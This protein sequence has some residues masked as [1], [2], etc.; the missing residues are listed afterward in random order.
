MTWIPPEVK[1]DNSS[2]QPSWTP[3][4]VKEEE[5]VSVGDSQSLATP[6]VSTQEEVATPSATLS[7][8]EQQT[9]APDFMGLFNKKEQIKQG[10]NVQQLK[11]VGEAAKQ[12]EYPV[13][14]LLNKS[15]VEKRLNGL[16]TSFPEVA[17]QVD[18]IKSQ[19]ITPQNIATIDDSVSQIEDSLVP[20]AITLSAAL[21]NPQVASSIVGRDKQY[22]DYYKNIKDTESKATT[23]RIVADTKKLN[24]AYDSR[25]DS[26]YKAVGSGFSGGIKEYFDEYANSR[27][28]FIKN[29]KVVSLIEKVKNMKN[30][31]SI[32]LSSEDRM[33]LKLWADNDA[34][35]KLLDDSIP[36]SY[37]IGKGAGYSVPYMGEFLLTAWTGTPVATAITR[38]VTSKLAEGAAVSFAKKQAIGLSAKLAATGIQTEFMPS[39]YRKTAEDV[40][41]GEDFGK[42]LL[43][44]YYSTFAENFTERLFLKNPWDKEAVGLVDGF[45]SKL[46][47]NL[48]SDKGAVGALYSLGE[49]YVEEKTS[50]LMTAP[51]DSNSFKEFW[52]NFWDVEKNGET[53]GSVALITL[54]MS[55]ASIMADKIGTNRVGKKIPANIKSEIDA[56]LADKKL[57]LK[58]QYD[59]VG[60]IVSDH[61]EDTDL[62]ST[63]GEMAG[64][65]IN[66]VTRKTRENVVSGIEERAQAPTVGTREEITTEDQAKL[67]YLESKGV[68]VPDGS[69]MATVNRL[70][71]EEKQKET[72][73]IKEE[74]KVAESTGVKPK[75]LRDVYR[76]GREIF[77]LN[78]AQALAQAIIVDRVVA[79]AAKNSGKTKQQIYSEIEYRKAD[80]LLKQKAGVYFQAAWHGSPYQID[81]FSWDHIGK[82]EGVQA[83]GWGGYFSDLRDIGED[84]ARKLAKKVLVIGDTS[85][86]VGDFISSDEKISNFEEWMDKTFP[87]KN[88]NIDSESLFHVISSL[89]WDRNVK[90]ITS[91][92]IKSIINERY[93]KKLINTLDRNYLL[94]QIKSISNI[95]LEKNR[96]LYKVEL[97]KGKTTEQ[98]DWLVWDKPMP[99]SM[100]EKI[101]KYVGDDIFNEWNEIL[102]ENTNVDLTDGELTGKEIYSFLTRIA[103]EDGLPNSSQI[104]D[105]IQ[106]EASLFLLRAGI[107][108]I[109]YPAESIARG[110]T[111]ETARG[112]NYVVFD[113]N[114]VTIEEVI[115]FQK[116]L[117]GKRGAMAIHDGKSLIYALTDPNVSTPLHEIAH[118]YERYMLPSEKA[119]VLAWT[120]HK[121]WS[122]ETSEKF[123]RGFEKYLA[124]GVAPTE[125]LKAVFERFKTWLIDIYNGIKQ[126]EI[127]VELN[128][129]MKRLYDSILTGKKYTPS[130]EKVATKEQEVP[131]K[132]YKDV[133]DLLFQV[134]DLLFQ[135]EDVKFQDTDKTERHTKALGNLISHLESEKSKDVAKEVN[136]YLKAKGNPI[137]QELIDKVLK[138]KGYAEGIRKQDKG[139]LGTQK[140][141]D[142]GK[143]REIPVG[144]NGKDKKTP[145]GK[146]EKVTGETKQR[147]T[148]TSTLTKAG[149]IWERLA[150]EA[151]LFYEVRKESEAIANAVKWL[152]EREESTIQNA[153]EGRK[154]GTPWERMDRRM[155][156][157]MYLKEKMSS[158]IEQGK[159]E[160]ANAVWENIKKIEEAVAKEGTEAGWT[161]Q[162]L[163]KFKRLDDISTT[164]VINNEIAKHNQSLYPETDIKKVS[165]SEEDINK[166][167]KEIVN[168]AVDDEKLTNVV[169][170]IAEKNKGKKRTE[171]YSEKAKEIADKLR[172]V[173]PSNW[174]ITLA[175]GPIS[176]IGIG[177]LDGAVET[178]AKAIE[179]SGNI[180]DSINKGINQIKRSDWYK[181]LNGKQKRHIE[182]AFELN[183]KKDLG[184]DALDRATLEKYLKR[185]MKDLGV[186]LKYIIKE[187]WANPT[188][189]GTKLSDRIVAN[190]GL[191]EAE[192]KLVEKTV[193]D[194]IRQKLEDKIT[195]SILNES[196][197]KSKAQKEIFLN[198]MGEFLMMGN[199]EHKYFREAFAE[200]FGL[201]PDITAEQVDYLTKLNKAVDATKDMGVY[202]DIVANQL[203]Q[204]IDKLIPKTKTQEL[205]GGMIGLD[206]ANALSGFTTHYINLKS[207]FWNLLTR[208]IMDVTDGA[209][210]IKS[211]KN[212]KPSQMPIANMFNSWIDFFF[213]SGKGMSEFIDIVKN[214]DLR[215]MHK[216]IS[217][218]KSIAHLT[219]PELER[220][221]QGKDRFKAVTVNINGKQ[222]DINVANY[223]KFVGRALAAE[224][225]FSTRGFDAVELAN[226]LRKKMRKQG[227]SESQIKEQIQRQ[228]YGWNLTEKEQK[229]VDD[230][231]AKEKEGL[232]RFGFTTD[233]YKDNRR[234]LEIIRE[235]LLDL[236]EQD[237]LDLKEVA[238]GNVFNDAR[239]GVV[240][241]VMSSLS[242]FANKNIWTKLGLMPHFMFFKIA[243]NI[244]D[245]MIDT[246]P[247]YGSLR[248]R[249]VTPTTIAAHYSKYRADG[250][251]VVDATQKAIFGA[252][253]STSELP[254][255][256]AMLGDKG[257]YRREQQ[258]ARARLGNIIMLS[259]FAVIAGL[260]A[261]G[262]DDKDENGEPWFDIS[263]GRWDVKDVTKREQELMPPY[264]IK[265]G[266][267]KFRYGNAPILTFGMSMVGN[268][269]DMI[270]AGAS[271]EEAMQRMKLMSRSYAYSIAS[272]TDQ[273]LMQGFKSITQSISEL[274]KTGVDI[275]KEDE[276]GESQA[277]QKIAEKFGKYI[278][279]EQLSPFTGWLPTKNNVFQQS[280]QF[281]SKKA[282]ESK[283]IPSMLAY[284]LGIHQFTNK[285]ALDRF[286][287]D[288][289]R[290]PGYTGIYWEPEMITSDPKKWDMVRWLQTNN[291]FPASYYNRDERFVYDTPKSKGWLH[292]LMGDKKPVVESKTPTEDQFYE[293]RKLEGNML[294]K[295]LMRYKD[296]TYEGKPIWE[297]EAKEQLSSGETVMQQKIKKYVSEAKQ[298][299]KLYLFTWADIGKKDP[300]LFK[301]LYESKSLPQYETKVPVF[302]RDLDGGIYKD[303][304][305]EYIVKIKQDLVSDQLAL[306]NA[307]AF[308]YYMKLMKE[309]RTTDT[310]ELKQLSDVMWKVAVQT[311]AAEYKGE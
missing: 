142:E 236:E 213:V 92:S 183:V 91:D 75:N 223:M 17:A 8:Q 29:R 233:K 302:K 234:R 150:K 35:H 49:E 264:T 270:N 77:G 188:A 26:W 123:A 296:A 64:N 256:T 67:D 225:A 106:K 307:E 31:P 248:A 219:V 54:P 308:R 43:K 252:R 41:K 78:K 190:L 191:T 275:K 115:K 216:Y 22:Y 134:D 143:E 33:L 161:V 220:Q 194:I 200:K 193:N 300:T 16:K 138:E 73:V 13:E 88:N 127:D 100:A 187:H 71:E 36:T 65:V 140:G 210:W 130:K 246:I 286:G 238:N 215:A 272:L 28:E 118:V 222:V 244:G 221:K 159:T 186:S 108:G 157:M 46:G 111:S 230:Q 171:T 211:I 283:D 12:A 70:Y 301:Q 184:V 288:V 298:Q 207:V 80:E 137:S 195:N 124:E 6:V 163:A 139:D 242:R 97:H 129:E 30:D 63:P 224:D 231:L 20:N 116:Q 162:A 281:I 15:D 151:P 87:P 287:D 179:L 209:E 34:A 113:E 5:P 196:L 239:G 69:S 260:Y 299:T 172:K 177:I 23:E 243:G 199:I 24:E 263:G 114:A 278:V 297:R 290:K 4:E 214:G 53:L 60:K 251:S 305:G 131:Q 95:T 240:N 119:A 306:F 128:T 85:F 293:M 212:G 48:H 198:K 208:P 292:D 9:K 147:G 282:V 156:Y 295:D 152:S 185:E 45:A 72:S 271:D 40:S 181:G 74:A 52:N 202:G 197:P 279:K 104:D 258:L 96:F 253:L 37:K 3:P 62:K 38:G 180:A 110:A 86:S 84:Y 205:L 19:Q 136:D 273:Q 247:A 170:T 105:N 125:K 112:F 120:G 126:S 192:A 285:T 237:I 168:E 304:N 44:N 226:A 269:R 169:N 165:E 59:L 228:V 66:Y 133:D 145:R 176:S 122:V 262:G 82:G 27:E 250:M 235:R 249:G 148:Q 182:R 135:S 274:W 117:Q 255:K 107:D 90:Q 94:D 268:Y 276:T 259:N 229:E 57:S 175:A 310:Q 167:S 68:K 153:L 267:Y 280:I 265:I 11:Q 166:L 245:F 227:F 141:V 83:F 14:F 189:F 25:N 58:D 7:F 121:T 201:T 39:L 99:K 55:G 18:Q 149:G 303:E 2:S 254:F 98:Y 10:I 102:I 174:G 309:A 289:K 50:E 132:T 257:S 56:V 173:K 206:Y 311:K 1:S 76:A 146:D 42:S 164:F 61:S 204:E 284:D 154:S 51:I 103:S 158:F 218:V 79:K 217:E 160:E 47:V 277:A 266:G 101:R 109:K 155:I 144:D 291:A 89:I 178:T 232:K 32:Q 93:S 261:I 241:A 203:A 21:N 81:K 294:K